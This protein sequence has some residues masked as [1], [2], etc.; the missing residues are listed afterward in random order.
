MQYFHAVRFWEN[1]MRIYWLEINYK[2]LFNINQLKVS[3]VST[4]M[5]VRVQCTQYSVHRRVIT[6]Y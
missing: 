1:T 4:I 6:N 2:Y 5:E 3:T